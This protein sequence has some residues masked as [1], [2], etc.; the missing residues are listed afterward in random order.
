MLELKSSA[1]KEIL[2]H[3]HMERSWQGLESDSIGIQSHCT[4][5]AGET[6]STHVPFWSH[7]A[8]KH[9]SS[10]AP[11]VPSCASPSPV[12]ASWLPLSEGVQAFALSLSPSPTLP[13][14]EHH[15]PLQL[16][17][18]PKLRKK[19]RN[20]KIC[21][22]HIQLNLPA[23]AVYNPV[24]ISAQT[25]QWTNTS[26]CHAYSGE[27]ALAEKTKAGKIWT[28]W[29]FKTLHSRFTPWTLEKI[30]THLHVVVQGKN[31]D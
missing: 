20:W 10:A 3:N 1:A 6:V 11:C 13:H 7:D 30:W 4:E 5:T 15:L 17:L 27:K 29:S 23:K 22:R 26:I 14:R 21:K 8:A 2:S 12:P 31:T 25:L 19:R 9:K 28:M 16:W 24:V 18:L